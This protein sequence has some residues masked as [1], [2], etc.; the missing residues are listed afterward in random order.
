MCGHPAQH[1]STLSLTH[2]HKPCVKG[3]G[4]HVNMPVITLIPI[5][6]HTH[7]VLPDSALCEEPPPSKRGCGWWLVAGWVRWK[8]GR[9]RVYALCWVARSQRRER[10]GAKGCRWCRELVGRLLVDTEDGCRT[11]H[12]QGDA[13]LSLSSAWRIRCGRRSSMRRR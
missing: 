2:Q 11:R 3:V 6:F 13:L 5:H 1:S 7:D 12:I 10:G 8:R 9:D 4:T